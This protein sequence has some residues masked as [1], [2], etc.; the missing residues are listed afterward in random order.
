VDGSGALLHAAMAEI[1]N[2][3]PVDTR[4]GRRGWHTQ[5]WHD[6]NQS[7]AH[8]RDS[9]NENAITAASANMATKAETVEQRTLAPVAAAHPAAARLARVGTLPTSAKLNSALYHTVCH[10]RLG[11][12]A[13]VP[14]F[15]A[16]IAL[17]G[18][19]SSAR[20]S[21]DS[22]SPLVSSQAGWRQET[23]AA[24][25]PICTLRFRCS[26]AGTSP[27]ETTSSCSLVKTIGLAPEA[28]CAPD[29]PGKGIKNPGKKVR[30]LVGIGRSTYRL[31][32]PKAHNGV[33]VS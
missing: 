13:A 22:R 12:T 33:L 7:I 17:L 5:G 28:R 1:G 14:L 2:K 16:L 18:R 31:F 27:R 25:Q 29:N 21:A 8:K 20:L 11:H 10:T 19:L 24:A 23:A 26:S 15:A 4:F 3:V 9:S 30:D 32:G 6:Q